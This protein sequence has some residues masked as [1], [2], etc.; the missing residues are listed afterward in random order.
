M[1][2]DIDWIE[3]NIIKTEFSDEQKKQWT[4][5]VDAIAVAKG[6]SFVREGEKGGILYLVRSGS[7][8]IFQHMDGQEQHLAGLG[9][10]AMIGEVTFLSGEAATATATAAADTLL[11]RLKR[12]DFSRLMQTS[13]ETVFSL[14]TYMLLYQSKM[15]HQRNEDQVK[16]MSFMTGSHK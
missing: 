8:D 12:E 1:N 6:E 16:M 10:A 9:E 13:P 4:N 11:Y 14:F 3:Q 15:V 2:I 5:A 7:V